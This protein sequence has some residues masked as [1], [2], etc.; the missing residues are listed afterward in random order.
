MF[1]PEFE[2]AIRIYLFAVGA[3]IVVAAFAIGAWVF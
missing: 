2:A 1:G 3:L